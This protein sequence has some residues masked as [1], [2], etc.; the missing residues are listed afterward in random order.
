MSR[1]YN[2]SAGPAVLPE[3]VLREAADEMMDYRGCGMS[4]MEMCHRSKV[5]D[6]IIKEAEADKKRPGFWPA[7]R[8]PELLFCAVLVAF[9][10]EC[11][12]DDRL[13]D[14]QRGDDHPGDAGQYG[15]FL[16]KAQQAP[17]DFDDGHHGGACSAQYLMFGLTGGRHRTGDVHIVSEKESSHIG[18][19]LRKPAKGFPQSLFQLCTRYW[20]IPIF[21]CRCAGTVKRHAQMDVRFWRRYVCTGQRMEDE[22]PFP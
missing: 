2:F 7:H 14:L 22:A 12:G 6:T 11:A 21:P 15:A 1:V 20:S 18:K 17:G 8:C 5:Y 3:E 4:V 13:S 10:D 19:A 16:G 9:A